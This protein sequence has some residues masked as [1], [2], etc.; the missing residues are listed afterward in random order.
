VAGWLGSG[1]LAVA[2]ARG[3]HLQGKQ[4]AAEAASQRQKIEEAQKLAVIKMA[5]EAADKKRAQTN[6][7]RSFGLQKDR[8]DWEKSKPAPP[9]LGSPEYEA[10]TL[11][12]KEGGAK[13]DAQYKE[14]AQRNID[15]LSGAGIQAQIRLAQAKQSAG[16]GEEPGKPPTEGER[17]SAGLLQQMERSAEV[18]KSYQPK[19][20]QVA[21]KIP[22]L[23]NYALKKDPQTQVALQAGM[24][25][26]RAYTYA[27]S[28]AAIN[29]NEA[30]EAAKT[31]IAQPGDSPE[32]LAQKR[33]AVDE[34]IQTVQTMGGRAVKT[35]GATADLVP[36]DKPQPDAAAR[37]KALRAK[38]GVK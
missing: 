21:G 24:Q 15:P 16:I 5:M 33:A 2:K 28:G 26:V 19:I 22:I 37:A 38:Y 30:E 32:V 20:S 31:Y 6:T 13:I 27:V 7:D 17:R 18:V 8:F 10:A 25:L 35:K 34:M 29:A 3:A 14:P 36:A 4:Q 12:L 11:R 23:G 9:I 1:L